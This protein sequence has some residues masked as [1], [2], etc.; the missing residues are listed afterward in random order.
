[1]DV[2]AARKRGPRSARRFSR[3]VLRSTARVRRA[4]PRVF[5]GVIGL[6]AVAAAALTLQVLAVERVL[7]AIL[8]VAD[9]PDAIDRLWLPVG[10]LAA[11][12]AVSNVTGA[13]QANLERLLAARVEAA[14]WHDILETATAVDLA[15]FEE[16]EFFDRLQ[17]IE[18]NALYRPYQVTQGLVVTAGGI[19]ASLG[20]GAALLTLHPAVLPLL[21]L[22]GL[23][24]VLTSRHESRLEFE[25][26]V[27]Q[28]P[29]QR[30]REY[31]TLLQTG[32]D[33]AA[34]V[35]A[36]GVAPELRRRL[37]RLYR[38]HFADLRRHVARRSLLTA[39]GNV[40]AAVALALT[41]GLLVWLVARGEVSVS[42]AGAAIV[43]I[44][45]LAGQVQAISTGIR[46][47][48]ESGLFLDDVDTFLA[49][50]VP[51]GET[52]TPVRERPRGGRGRRRRPARPASAP[53]TASRP[54]THLPD[55]PATFTML[56]ARNLT[57][58]YPGAARPALDGVDVTIRAGEVVALV[59]E[60]GSGKTT[61]TKVLAGLYA[62][63]GGV[64]QWDGVDATRYRAAALRRRVTVI[65]QDF[66]EYAFSA[67][68]NVAIGRPD[69]APDP[70]RVRA[71]ARAAG[72]DDVLAGLPEGYD[73][74]LSREFPGGQDLSG[75][76]WQ[77]V[78]L[79]RALYR[80]A[81]LVVLDEP[82]AAMDARAE[83]DLFAS[84]RAVLA[85]RSAVVV[86]HRFS[87][88]RTADRIY[89]LAGG[90]VVEQGTHEQLM[91]VD[92]LY[93]DLFRLQAAAY[94]PDAV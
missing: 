29:N 82:T 44:R 73:T 22:G 60:N 21:L 13:V 72:I 35:R 43:A 54:A 27:S 40:G 49:L 70:A 15:R 6:Q 46:L 11:V 37:D 81:P 67:T 55:P 58:A 88:V 50:D 65:F 25:F 30:M 34:E 42:Q 10:V 8:A 80:D 74:P 4:G 86:S 89:V 84:L 62:P 53:T 83:H 93:A 39:V 87:T 24:L 16:P 69:E 26:A 59:G 9:D 31:L 20:L 68:D 23:P 85:G 77:R 3:L 41:L 92:G 28:T 36:F 71:A 48:F 78:A 61:L 63:T 38:A 75:G 94:L 56:E 47:V 52:P 79:A 33:E 12:T 45:M 66:V 17:R 90:R 2:L 1:M 76:Q 57:F 19:L 32:R 7:T 64:V 18:T 14:T 5:G 51:D 91:A